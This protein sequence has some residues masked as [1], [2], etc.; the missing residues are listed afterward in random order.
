MLSKITI[1]NSYLQ[2]IHY[3]FMMNKWIFLSEPYSYQFNDFYGLVL[4][5]NVRAILS[6]IGTQS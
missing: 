2:T 6:N 1:Y 3:H 5:Y 4:I